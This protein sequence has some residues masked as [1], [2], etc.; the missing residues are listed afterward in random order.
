[1]GRFS[2]GAGA[3]ANLLCSPIGPSLRFAALMLRRF[4]NALASSVGKKIV[5]GLT[6]LLLV[7]FLIE[8]LHGNL[9]LYEGDEAFDGYVAFMKSFGPLLT[10]AELGLAALFLCHVFLAFRLTM[11][12]REARRTRYVFRNHR[13]AQTFGSVSMFVT[14]ALVLAFLLKHLSDFRFGDGFFD[15]PAETVRRTLSQPGT[16]LIYVVG[17][18]VLGVHLSHGIRSGLQS[19]GVNHPKL[20]AVLEKVGIPIAIFFAVAFASFPVYFCFFWSE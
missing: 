12:N 5:M 8:H 6:G 1:M 3:R 13:G 7:G 17:A 10:V 18:A 4:A 16:A 2:S 20:N 15:A 9:Y 14:G 11:E 19:L